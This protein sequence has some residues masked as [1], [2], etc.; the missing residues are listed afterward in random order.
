MSGQ[1]ASGY[2]PTV[3]SFDPVSESFSQ[4]AVNN[5]QIAAP[6]IL[7]S[8]GK[9]AAMTQDNGGFGPTDDMEIL[10]IYDPVADQW[11]PVGPHNFASTLGAQMVPLGNGKFLL[12]GGVDNFTFL[13]SGSRAAFIFDENATTSTGIRDE[14]LPSLNIIRPAGKREIRITGDEKD[15]STVRGV[16]MLD[17]TGRT[18]LDKTYPSAG[19]SMQLPEV[20]EG[21]YLIQL[22]DQAGNILLVKKI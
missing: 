20:A 11:T 15:L 3:E 4:A 8:N 7:M 21:L 9:V 17:L 22:Y 1:G 16:R 19:R 18:I 10:E 12:A 6:L 5:H 14:F 2:N 13:N